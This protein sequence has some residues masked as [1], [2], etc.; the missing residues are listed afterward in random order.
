VQNFIL[1]AAIAANKWLGGVVRQLG[2]WLG[3][4]LNSLGALPAFD[5]CCGSVGTNNKKQKKQQIFNRPIILT[6]M[7][8]Q[9]KTGLKLVDASSRD[10]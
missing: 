6:E 8:H 9:R 10:E 3:R 4:S 1:P 2:F 7:I 5:C